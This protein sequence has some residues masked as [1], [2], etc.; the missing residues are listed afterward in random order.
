[1]LEKG[2][3]RD[4]V[5]RYKYNNPWQLVEDVARHDFRSLPNPE[6]RPDLNEGLGGSLGLD[7]GDYIIPFRAPFS[8]AAEILEGGAGKDD[9]FVDYRPQYLELAPEG[10]LEKYQLAPKLRGDNEV[11]GTQI[12]DEVLILDRGSEE[13]YDSFPVDELAKDFFGEELEGLDIVDRELAGELVEEYSNI[14]TVSW[15]T[16]SDV[17]Y[18]EDEYGMDSSI[19]HD[20][21]H[22]AGLLRNEHSPDAGVLHFP[23]RRADELPES[24]QEKYFDTVLKP[25]SGDEE[26]REDD[27]EQVGLTDF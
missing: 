12:I 23:E 8:T 10:A 4:A 19:L 5:Q 25:Q 13:V 27:T 15:A 26:E 2:D 16:T 17:T 11:T 20:R 6:F 14:R 9:V 3:P 7:E 21:L 1:M 22:E 18:L 24:K